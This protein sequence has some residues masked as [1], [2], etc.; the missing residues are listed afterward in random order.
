LLAEHAKLHAESAELSAAAKTLSSSHAKC[1]VCG[2]D[3]SGGRA[4]KLAGAKKT[5]S[6]R[7]GG[8]AKKQA[9]EI[10]GKNAELEELQDAVS[11]LALFSSE[12]ERI[13]SEGADAPAIEKEVAEKSEK[14]GELSAGHKKCGEGIAKAEDAVEGAKGKFEEAKQ[15]A[16]LFEDLEAAASALSEVEKQLASLDFNEMHYEAERK[17]AEEGRVEFARADAE[18]KGEE[19]QLALLGQMLSLEQSALERLLALQA[20]AKKYSEA[21]ESM[22]LYKNSLAATQSELRS[23][24]V[25]EINQALAEIW[26]AIYP[27]GDYGGAKLEADEKD[28]RLLLQKQAAWM[29]VDAVASGG[30]RACLCL[31]LRIAFATVL[32]PDIGWL[33]LDEPTHNLDSDAVQ[34]LA[35]AINTKIPSIVE[36]TFVITHDPVL[37]ES[38]EGT[39]FR[40]ERDKNKNEPTRV[41]Q[42]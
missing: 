16:K 2:S 13:S 8:A 17:A 30:E 7:K 35:E 6:E 12:L 1:P 18:C 20:V 32:T 33:I 39:V 9:A 29:D 41:L 37:G 15:S 36:Q 40:L 31:A 10:K 38:G 5:E 4:E 23:Q 25:E 26:P 11:Q 27:Y 34:T 22:V 14:K 42:G 28:Y 3:L 24:L 19:R 21:Q